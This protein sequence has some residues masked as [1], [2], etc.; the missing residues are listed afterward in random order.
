[1]ANVAFTRSDLL[2][3]LLPCAPAATL[4]APGSVDAERPARDALQGLYVQTIHMSAHTPCRLER[5]RSPTLPECS[6]APCWWQRWQQCCVSAGQRT[7][8]PAVC[9][10]ACMHAVYIC[11]LP[12]CQLSPHAP[13]HRQ[14]HASLVAQRNNW[15]RAVLPAALLPC[16]RTECDE[17]VTLQCWMAER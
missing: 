13:S 12:R 11:R 16:D 17:L 2:Q 14:E 7:A 15:C 8:E 1:M 3:A 10:R 4:Q 6:L 5:A 9:V